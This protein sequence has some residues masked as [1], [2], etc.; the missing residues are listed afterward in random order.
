MLTELKTS[1]HCPVNADISAMPS[2]NAPADNVPSPRLQ[3]LLNVAPTQRRDGFTS[4]IE[5][6]RMLLT[7][8]HLPMLNSKT[9]TIVRIAQ[10]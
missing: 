5:F 1:A 3:P 2:A 7:L 8:L 6:V 10:R 9:T 4:G